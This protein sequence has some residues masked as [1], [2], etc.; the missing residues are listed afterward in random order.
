MEVSAKQTVRG[1]LSE[2]V[3]ERVLEALAPGW[4]LMGAAL[5]T[6]GALAMRER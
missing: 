1:H 2:E 4:G 3:F 6:G 5:I